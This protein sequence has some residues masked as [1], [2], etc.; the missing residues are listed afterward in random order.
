MINTNFGAKFVSDVT[1]IRM[2]DTGK[3]FPYHEELERSVKQGKAE[4]VV[5]RGGKPE[6]ISAPIPMPKILKDISDRL[7]TPVHLAS[8]GGFEVTPLAQ[9]QGAAPILE[10]SKQAIT[11]QKVEAPSSVSEVSVAAKEEYKKLA[12]KYNAKE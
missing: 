8:E 6:K 12:A 9:L 1:Y 2:V 5:F 11:E 10:A 4:Y 7:R 3:I